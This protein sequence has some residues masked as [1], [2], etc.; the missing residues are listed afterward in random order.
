MGKYIVRRLLLM[1]PILVGVSFI[2][3]LLVASL[4]GGI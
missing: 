3:F 1:I 2:V 4:P